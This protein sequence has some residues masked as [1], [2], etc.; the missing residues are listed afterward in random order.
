MPGVPRSI[1]IA[2]I[3]DSLCG[4]EKRRRRSAVFDDRSSG[5]FRHGTDPGAQVTT[6]GGV[7]AGPSWSVSNRQSCRPVAR[8]SLARLS[9]ERDP[10]LR[11]TSGGSWSALCA[12]GFRNRCAAGPAN[13][14]AGPARTSKCAW[15]QDK[16]AA[17][18]NM[19][20][21]STTRM[22]ASA[23]PVSTWSFMSVTP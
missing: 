21:T 23:S 13:I 16:A 4:D 3:A 19:T 1:A 15:Y 2:C 22:P 11:P 9:G 12:P 7:A 20:P 8:W 18:A 14:K 6:A 17:A 10:A 5:P